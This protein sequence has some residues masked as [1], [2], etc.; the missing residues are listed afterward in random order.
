M[1]D[2]TRVEIAKVDGWIG[3]RINARGG[4]DSDEISTTSM[5]ATMEAPLE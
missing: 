3:I 4:G 1:G 5:F 2:T